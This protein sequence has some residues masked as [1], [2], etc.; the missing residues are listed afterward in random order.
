MR[1]RKL[2]KSRLKRPE[3]ERPLLSTRQ[4]KRHSKK[5]NLPKI[6]SM[7]TVWL[8]GVQ[9]EPRLSLQYR[10]K[11]GGKYVTTGAMIASVNV[12]TL[13]QKR[14][15]G[16]SGQLG[17][18]ATKNNWKVPALKHLM[19]SKGIY[20]LG[21]QETRRTSGILDV[22]DGYL[23]VTSQNEKYSW[24]GG[25]GFLLSPSA[26]EAFRATN[27]LTWSPPT[28]SVASGRY[29]EIGLA[30]ASRKEGI[31]TFANGYGPTAQS[32]MEVRKAFWDIVEMRMSGTTAGGQGC[33]TNGEGGGQQ[34]G[35]TVRR[36]RP[37]RRIYIA[38]GDWNARVGR[39]DNMMGQHY[40]NVIGPHNFPE[41]NANGSMMLDAMTR[42][43]MKIA[44][45]FFKHDKAH[46]TTWTHAGTSKET[47]CSGPCHSQRMADATC[48][49]CEGTTGMERGQRP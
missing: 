49:G 24:L 21:L 42:C 34:Q 1:K 12:C 7:G 9:G 45:T 6:D 4:K 28:G 20:L 31:L 15:V 40:E 32:D 8:K 19:R 26:A 11:I 30:S 41:R 2:R 17:T 29:L 5:K 35:A 22:G 36:K 37:A 16:Y 39:R 25:T 27:C 43:G 3:N 48:F 33:T 44:N 18:E 10:I 38:V 23:L 46:T 14:R 13:R 47:S